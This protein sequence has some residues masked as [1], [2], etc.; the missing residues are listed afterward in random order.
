[1]HGAPEL[2]TAATAMTNF[3][4]WMKS[5][6]DIFELW[7]E[8]CGRVNKMHVSDRL[9][10]AWRRNAHLL[11]FRYSWNRFNTRTNTTPATIFAIRIFNFNFEYA[12]GHWLCQSSDS[13][14]SF[15]CFFKFEFQSFPPRNR[16]TIEIIPYAIANTCYTFFDLNS[17]C[18]FVKVLR[19]Q[20]NSAHPAE[21]IFVSIFRWLIFVTNML[22]VVRNEF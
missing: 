1:M 7:I 15:Q 11:N 21:S 16:R 6:T 22:K 18:F 14:D 8:W 9:A 3:D 17:V 13:V 5:M 10:L 2:S 20:F 12:R 19:A 4:K